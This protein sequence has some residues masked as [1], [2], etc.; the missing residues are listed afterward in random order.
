[1]KLINLRLKE[2]TAGGP[3]RYSIGN[4]IIVGY[5]IPRQYIEKDLTDDFYEELKITGV[6]VL[7]GKQDGVEKVYVGQSDNVSTRLYKH[8][9]GLEG[10]KRSGKEFWSECVAFVSVASL[11]HKGH[12]EFLEGTFYEKIRTAERYFIENQNM[13]T[14][15]NLSK[16]EKKFCD[17]FID[18]CELLLKL[19][20]V[21]LFCHKEVDED[22]GGSKFDKLM[23]CN[24][25]KCSSEDPRYINAI[26]YIS[27]TEENPDRFV[28]LEKSIINSFVSK[29]ARASIRKLRNELMKKGCI[30]D[31]NGKLIFKQKY[32]FKSPATAASFVLGRNASTKDWK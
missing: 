24:G 4:K 19:M 9:G 23:I 6:Y 22:D 17:D 7:L 11:I 15:K 27:P 8:R 5:K 1:M 2:G 28:V 26:G 20:G 32:S 31:E 21:P 12:A 18:D 10:E 16:A 25:D 13:P 3:Q 30:K 14:E 29:K